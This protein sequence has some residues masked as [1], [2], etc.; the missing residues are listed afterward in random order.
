MST[1]AL[2][3]ILILAGQEPKIQQVPMPDLEHCMAALHSFMT[4]DSVKGA[5]NRGGIRQAA[6]AEVVPKG[7][8]A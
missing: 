1:F 6:C 8:P 7:N 5:I 2:L 3:V 4:S